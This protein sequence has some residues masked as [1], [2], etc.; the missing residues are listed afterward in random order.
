MSRIR[1]AAASTPLVTAPA[2]PAAP[3]RKPSPNSEMPTAAATTGLI[4]VTVASGAVRP[5]PR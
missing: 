4:T 2:V 3:N 5:A 1:P